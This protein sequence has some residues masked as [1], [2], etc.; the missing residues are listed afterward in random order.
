MTKSDRIKFWLGLPIGALIGYGITF[1]L[2]RVLGIGWIPIAIIFIA[3]SGLYIL[4]FSPKLISTQLYTEGIVATLANILIMVALFATI[5]AHVGIIDGEGNIVKSFRECFYF[6]MVTWTTLGYG[7]YKPSV[8]VQM[9][10]VLEAFL[11][12][13]YLAILAAFILGRIMPTRSNDE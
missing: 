6:S 1:F 2:D 5:Y 10:A 9:Y 11:G 3:W 12:Y 7:D 13:I 8:P 4:V